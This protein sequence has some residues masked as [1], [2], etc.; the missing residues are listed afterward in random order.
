M[1]GI[2]FLN[3][4][5]SKEAE[6]R[7]S[8]ILGELRRYVIKSLQQRGISGEQKD[9]M[10][11]VLIAIDLNSNL[12]DGISSYNVQYSGANNP[13]YIIRNGKS[14]VEEIKS[15]KMPIAIHER[16][17]PF[18][19]NDIQLKEGDLVYL[20]TDGYADQFGGPNRKKFMYKQLKSVLI[21][22]S[23]KEMMYV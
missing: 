18:T 14:E 6:I 22:N 21:N 1:L 13:L 10:D 3:E 19:N 20:F 23:A 7:T 15:D 17:D 8:A 4:I 16:M 9:G 5:T 12:D 11:I 2:S